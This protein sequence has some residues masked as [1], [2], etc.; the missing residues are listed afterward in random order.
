MT[1]IESAAALHGCWRLTSFVIEDP[2]GARAPW[3]GTS[4]GLLIYTSS[5]HMSVSFNSPVA[6]DADLQELWDS[7]LLYSGRYQFD[8]AR[9]SILHQVEH[10][11]DPARIGKELVREAYFDGEELVLVGR[12]DFGVAS[13]RWRKES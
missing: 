7:A 6:A 12:G 13:V 4:T 11:S 8:A 5:G 1:P 10:A 9:S 2:Q 3:R